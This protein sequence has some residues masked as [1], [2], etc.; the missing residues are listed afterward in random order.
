MEQTKRIID[1]ICD[2]NYENLPDVAIENAKV[3]CLIF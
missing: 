2:T 3:V 1:F